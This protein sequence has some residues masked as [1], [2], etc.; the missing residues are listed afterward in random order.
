MF[1]A[2][3]RYGGWTN[4]AVAVS[5]LPDQ[6]SPPTPAKTTG[7]QR[8]LRTVLIVMCTALWTALLPPS[9]GAAETAQSSAKAANGHA[10]GRY[11]GLPLPRFASIRSHR[12]NLRRGPGT[13]YPIDWV[14]HRKFLPVEILREFYDWRYVRTPDGTKDWIHGALLSGRRTFRIGKVTATLRRAP[15]RDARA[16]A[17]LKPGVIGH[18]LSCEHLAAWCRVRVG[19]HRGY[20]RRD[21][22]WG[23]LPGEAIAE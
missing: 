21:T 14:V 10:V 17:L 1:Y 7:R 3:W 20:L 22:F 4:R 6:R 19:S 13:R 23:T 18:L 12:A 15:Q 5:A 16:V 9:R 8:R 11:T 2:R